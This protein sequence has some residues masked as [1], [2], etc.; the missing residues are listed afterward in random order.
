MLD[1]SKKENIDRVDC[2]RDRSKQ[3]QTAMPALSFS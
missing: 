1:M 2:V 3:G